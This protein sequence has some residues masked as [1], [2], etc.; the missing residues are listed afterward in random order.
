MD[1]QSCIAEQYCSE[2]SKGLPAAISWAE[3]CLVLYSTAAIAA[4]P[5]L[6]DGRSIG[7]FGLSC[8]TRLRLG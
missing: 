2:A 3:R 4:L 1:L 5:I 7:F 8:S 6:Q